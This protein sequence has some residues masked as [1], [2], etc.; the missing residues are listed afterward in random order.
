MMLIAVLPDTIAKQELHQETSIISSVS[1]EFF[2]LTAFSYCGGIE[3]RL[4]EYM[5]KTSLPNLHSQ[6][7]QDIL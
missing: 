6:Y 1:S 2:H 7:N 5:S 3:L 4:I